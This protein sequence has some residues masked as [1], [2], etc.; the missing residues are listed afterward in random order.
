MQIV[1]AEALLL[2]PS[3]PD[4]RSAVASKLLSQIHRSNFAMGTCLIYRLRP[5]FQSVEP[6]GFLLPF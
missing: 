2:S 6:G 1:A 3:W 4:L 5:I